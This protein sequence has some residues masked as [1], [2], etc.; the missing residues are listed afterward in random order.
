MQKMTT[1]EVTLHWA[2]QARKQTSDNIKLLLENFNNVQK[3]SKDDQKKL[4]HS[5][6]LSVWRQLGLKT[7]H[8]RE[9]SPSV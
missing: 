8:S 9:Q 3:H 6:C 5:L 1:K 4:P 7:S 2:I